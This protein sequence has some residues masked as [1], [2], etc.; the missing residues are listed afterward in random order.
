MA[1]FQYKLRR[2]SVQ[3]AE[4]RIVQ[5]IDDVEMT[6]STFERKLRELR[7]RD[8]TAFI[9]AMGARGAF[10]VIHDEHIAKRNKRNQ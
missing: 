10:G 9:L 4:K 2:T 6:T 3:K 8:L 5:Y 1:K 7:K